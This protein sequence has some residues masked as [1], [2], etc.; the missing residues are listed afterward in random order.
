[1]F[2]LCSN[3]YTIFVKFLERYVLREF[4]RI[5]NGSN[6]RSFSN[7]SNA[8]PW[9]LL[10]FW[11][12]R[13]RLIEGVFFHYWL[14]REG[15]FVRSIAVYDFFKTY[16][17]MLNFNYFTFWKTSSYSR[18]ALAKGRVFIKGSSCLDIP[19]HYIHIIDAWTSF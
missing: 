19:S 3:V 1:M 7:A 16:S 6:K 11:P 12:N 14:L 2:I 5:L 9:F 15:M 17:Y 10:H 8:R 13:E 4:E 18:W